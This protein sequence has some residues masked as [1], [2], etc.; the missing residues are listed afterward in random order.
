LYKHMEFQVFPPPIVGLPPL[1]VLV[2]NLTH[3]KR[4]GGKK[5]P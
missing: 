2:I 1:V 5:K 4:S 3:I